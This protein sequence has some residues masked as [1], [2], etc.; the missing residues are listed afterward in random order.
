[1]QDTLLKQGKKSW[2]KELQRSFRT[3]ALFLVNPD[4]PQR[5]EL[6][7]ELNVADRA[8]T[9]GTQKKHIQIIPF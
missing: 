1:M 9:F 2:K 5:F 6:H 4:L 7:A 8:I 3:V